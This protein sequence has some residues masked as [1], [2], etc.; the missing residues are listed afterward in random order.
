MFIVK[1]LKPK[2]KNLFIKDISHFIWAKVSESYLS[3][4]EIN[5]LSPDTL[6]IISIAHDYRQADDAN[7]YAEC[8]HKFVSEHNLAYLPIY[9]ALDDDLLMNKQQVFP[10]MDK[11]RLQEA[12]AWEVNDFM[13]DFVCAHTI[14]QNG[15]NYTV[16]MYF[17]AKDF[18]QLWQGICKGQKLDLM[19]ISNLST[20]EY[21][22]NVS[23][24]EE[25]LP[26][27]FNLPEAMSNLQ[28]IAR[29]TLA[30][31]LLATVPSKLRWRC[32]YTVFFSILIAVSL[33]YASF[34]YSEYYILSNENTRLQEKLQLLQADKAQ[35]EGIK[36]KEQVLAQKRERIKEIYAENLA[37]YP[38]LVGLGSTIHDG[39]Q[40]LAM[41]FNDDRIKIQGKAINYEALTAYK[42][43]LTSI[44]LVET[45]Q[46]ENSTAEN[47]L[48]DFT[49]KLNEAK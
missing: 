30:V 31:N 10:Q 28:L 11:G 25:I 44:K 4:L 48:I 2:L 41:D 38:L 20:G 1:N 22:I 15:D 7:F 40:I 19:G 12:I 16:N 42:Q 13:A 9:L 23:F 43:Q 3:L 8:L 26:E 36:A 45:V 33:C 17:C 6:Q 34:C 24:D 46:I 47:D 27:G 32:I 49:L 18:C 37:F 29:H 39:V 35:I 14:K 21:N 5:I